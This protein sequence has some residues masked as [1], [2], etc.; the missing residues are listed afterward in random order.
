MS[1][2][3][4]DEGLAS[5][6]RI[7]NVHKKMTLVVDI[8]LLSTFALFPF[9]FSCSC[10]YVAPSLFAPGC[11]PVPIPSFFSGQLVADWQRFTLLFVVTFTQVQPF[12]SSHERHQCCAHIWGSFI[13]RI[14]SPSPLPQRGFCL[15]QWEWRVR[16]SAKVICSS[17]SS[18]QL[19][20]TY[21]W[22]YWLV[23]WVTC[24]FH[25]YPIDGWFG[26][27][28]FGARAKLRLFDFFFF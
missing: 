18:V 26:Y 25:V 10:A 22:V 9:F 3:L 16:L 11:V 17:Q 24:Q 12:F 23:F 13:F 4:G 28:N 2:L 7:Y 15:D 20:R 6:R 21:I 19:L 27:L 14:A 8:I 1:L 5:R